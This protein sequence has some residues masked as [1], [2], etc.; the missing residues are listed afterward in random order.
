MLVNF[1]V[2]TLQA[3]VSVGSNGSTTLFFV[4]VDLNEYVNSDWI[5]IQIFSAKCIS[6]AK[7]LDRPYILDEKERERKKSSNPYTI[8]GIVL[9]RSKGE[10][11]FFFFSLAYL[12]ENSSS[13]HA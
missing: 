11:H 4:L 6:S 1:V 10:N 8:R 2:Q 3:F 13:N 5:C 9:R 12:N 7:K